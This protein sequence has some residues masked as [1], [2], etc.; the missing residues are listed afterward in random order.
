MKV[1]PYLFASLSII[2]FASLAYSNLMLRNR[3]I[4][5]EQALEAET[6]RT[7]E[8][9]L[10]MTLNDNFI[11][12]E[13][14]RS[15]KHISILEESIDVKNKKWA[16]VKQVRAII[17]KELESIGTTHN[18]SINEIT[19]IAAAIVDYSD[20]YDVPVPLIAAVMRTESAYDPLAISP[21]GASGL[22]QIVDSTAEEIAGDIGKRNY[23]IYKIAD[24]VQFGTFYLW[25]M[26]KRFKGDLDL[27]IRAYNCGP[28]YVMK[29]QAG[30]Y[31]SYPEETIRYLETVQSYEKAFKDAG[32]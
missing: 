14:A 18:Q 23:N 6:A 29:V 31:P 20:Q 4:S 13:N 10:Y 27:A 26:I 22:M 28:Q 17:Q 11:E 2:V 24:N 7:T 5:V 1:L 9:I 16:R 25:K 32:L 3:I 12:S 30:I 8:D 15:N 21:T 19:A